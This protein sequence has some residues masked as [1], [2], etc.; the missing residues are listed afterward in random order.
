MTAQ[1]YSSYMQNLSQ[2]DLETVLIFPYRSECVSIKPAVAVWRSLKHRDHPKS[3][4][5]LINYFNIL[6]NFLIILRL[7]QLVCI[8]PRTHHHNQTTKTLA[9]SIKIDLIELKRDLICLPNIFI[10]ITIDHKTETCFER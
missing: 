4:F 9:N 8:D 1:L 5:N 7:C 10:I 2:Y 3:A 6:L